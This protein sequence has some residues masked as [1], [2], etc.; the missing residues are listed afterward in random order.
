ML[1]PGVTLNLPAGLWGASSQFSKE[2]VLESRK[3]ASAR[4]HVERAI[5]RIKNYKILTRRVSRK[6]L[7]YLSKIFFVC[8]Y[9]TTLQPVLIEQMAQTVSSLYE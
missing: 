6:L 8:S 4:V 9:L 3:I 7:P 5:E 2:E 1:H